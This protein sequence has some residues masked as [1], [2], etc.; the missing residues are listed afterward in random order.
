M[1]HVTLTVRID[2]PISAP[3]ERE[4]ELLRFGAWLARPLDQGDPRT[5]AVTACAAHLLLLFKAHERGI[6][7]REALS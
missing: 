5:N 7:T 3:A 6:P 4:A 2:L 1:S